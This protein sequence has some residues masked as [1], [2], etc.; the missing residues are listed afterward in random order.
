MKIQRYSLVV[1]GLIF[2]SCSPPISE[3]PVVPLEIDQEI[4]EQA[5]NGDPEA[6]YLIGMN[7]F[8]GLNGFA[9]DQAKALEWIK[10]AADGGL[11]NAQ[12]SMGYFYSEGKILPPDEK[13]ATVWFWRAA[14]QGHAEATYRVGVQYFDGK[15]ITKD[16]IKAYAWLSLVSSRD[17]RAINLLAQIAKELAPAQLKQAKEFAT[18]IRKEI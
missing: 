3:E 2:I 4:L 11:D 7:Y 9:L 17:T 18:E 13:E 6:Q 15:G 5:Q 10:K 1:I 12:Y 16:L 8:E 14:N